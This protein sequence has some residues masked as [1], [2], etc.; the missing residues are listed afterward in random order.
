M[1]IH[2]GKENAEKTQK[3][4]DWIERKVERQQERRE[5]AR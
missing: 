3:R 2:T 1:K 4:Q 5:Q